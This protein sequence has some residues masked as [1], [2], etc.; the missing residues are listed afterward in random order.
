MPQ[1]ATTT[2]QIAS[3]RKRIPKPHAIKNETEYILFAKQVDN[4]KMSDIATLLRTNTSLKSL[5]FRG[6]VEDAGARAIASAMRDNRTLEK[7]SFDSTRVSTVGVTALAQALSTVCL[8]THLSLMY[9]PIRDKAGLLLVEVLA[10]P[11]CRLQ[12][13]RLDCCPDITN[14][15]GEA[16][17][18]TLTRNTNSRMKVAGLKS[19]AVDLNIQREITLLLLPGGRPFDKKTSP[20][21][22]AAA[23]LSTIIG[24]SKNELKT[25]HGYADRIGPLTSVNA[26]RAKPLPPPTETIK[27]VN[28][29]KKYAYDSRANGGT[30]K[31]T[32]KRYYTLEEEEAK[33]DEME[34]EINFVHSKRVLLPLLQNDKERKKGASV[35]NIKMLMKLNSTLAKKMS[36]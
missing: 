12:V 36:K 3:Q 17:L 26:V 29:Y 35:S 10:Q 19:T 25:L 8:L 32:S 6:W 21:C 24:P 31:S 20:S 11:L 33:E 1:F 14:V 28:A 16:M 4:S 18:Q 15:T 13:L 27:G 23:Y 22:E 5:E 9:L 30:K 2:V 7:L 34:E